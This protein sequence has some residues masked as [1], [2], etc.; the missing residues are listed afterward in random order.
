[1]PAWGQGKDRRRYERLPFDGGIHF[2]TDCLQ[3][4][5]GIDLSLGGVGLLTRDVAPV[6]NELEVAFLERSVAVR[7][8]VRS[9]RRVDDGYRLGIQFLTE[10]PEVV[11]VVR[12]YSP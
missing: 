2:G 5:T 9:V 11:E 7:G 4:A 10:E 1:M 6:G 3:T 8:V 12:R